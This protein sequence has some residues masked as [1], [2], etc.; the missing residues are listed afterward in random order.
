MAKK[1]RK[2]KNSRNTTARVPVTIYWPDRI[3]H[4]KAI[5][6]RGLSDAEMAA[7]M[8][9][10]DVL[11]DSWKAFYPAFAKAIDDGRTLPDAQ[12]IAALH[13]NAIGYDYETDEVV[14]T[15]KGAQV[16]T[17]KKHFPAE[18]AAQK[19]WL[20][21]RA[22]A[23]WNV[24]QV[25]AIGGRGKENPLHVSQETKLMVMHSILNMITPRPDGES[26]PPRVVSEQ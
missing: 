2:T 17:V 9:V 18:T 10:S 26:S 25:H 6:M 1:R 21:N 7:V 3:D 14:R 11:F 24:P 15:R 23:H 4:V 22:P 16:V 12:V 13:K 19:F 8:G 20:S 5:A